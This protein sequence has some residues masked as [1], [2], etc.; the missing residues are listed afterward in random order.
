MPSHSDLWSNLA[1]P[2]LQYILSLTSESFSSASKIIKMPFPLKKATFTLWYSYCSYMQYLHRTDKPCMFRLLIKHFRDTWSNIFRLSS[3]QWNIVLP[4]KWWIPE[5][6]PLAL[7]KP[8]QNTFLHENSNFVIF[9]SSLKA[10]TLVSLV[11]I[12]IG[13]VQMTRDQAQTACNRGLHAY[14]MSHK[15][16]KNLR[17]EP[18]PKLGTFGPRNDIHHYM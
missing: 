13:L 1:F 8:L 10:T 5:R 15:K 16:F 14:L 7:F 6:K 12:I 4:C 9:Q 17:T 11:A 18:K 3:I 2:Y